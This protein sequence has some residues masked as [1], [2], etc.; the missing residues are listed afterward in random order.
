MGAI[1]KAIDVFM[2]VYGIDVTYRGVAERIAQ[3][4]AAKG[5]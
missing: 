3:L 2:E 5:A 1:D 4:Q